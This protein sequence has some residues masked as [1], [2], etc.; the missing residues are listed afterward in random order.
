MQIM[1]WLAIALTVGLIFVAST[2][3]AQNAPTPTSVS[4]TLPPPP[5]EEEPRVRLDRMS[6]GVITAVLFVDADRG[7]R[8]VGTT[9]NTVCG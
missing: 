3:H 9:E 2:A 6:I 1:R 5:P 8:V 7:S 4:Q